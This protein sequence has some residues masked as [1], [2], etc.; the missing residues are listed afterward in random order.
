MFSFRTTALE[1]QLDKALMSGRVGV[2]STQNSWDP[3]KREYTSDIF[4]RRGNLAISFQPRYTEL[5]PETNHIEFDPDDLK[6]LSAIVVEIQD[7]GVRYFNYTKDVLRLM[8]ALHAIGEDAP[9]MYVVD[10]L[11]PAGRIVEGTMPSG[12][13]D[14]WMPRV[15]HR[16]GLT[17][18]ELT[19]LYYNELGARFALHVISARALAASRVLMPWTIAPSSDIAG[20][21]TCFMYSGGGLWNHTTVTPGIGTPRPY[22]Y[23][24]APF[25]KPSTDVAL[26]SPE[27]VLM[28]PCSFIP[29]VGR[30]EGEQ[31][32]GYQILLVPG[33]QY[34]SLLHTLQLMRYFSERYSGF[35]FLT[36]FEYKLADPFIMTY[37]RGEMS[38]QDL[39]EYVKTEEQKWIRKAKRYVLYDDSP[40]RIK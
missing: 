39:R 25:L 20:M 11:N 4:R 10:H 12:E 3:L 17:L 37:L 34:H 15:A 29:T 35:E 14:Q 28:R 5:S 2:F 32:F 9:A 8:T 24:G 13:T 26:P 38:F 16:H 21:F 40:V 30:Y 23:I 19:H 18:G 27:G 22:E 6:D 33:V 36:D 1:D 31:C 7:V